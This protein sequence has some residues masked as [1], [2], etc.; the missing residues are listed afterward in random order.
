MRLGRVRG[1]LVEVNLAMAVIKLGLMV[2]AM[3][4]SATPLPFE[5]VMQGWPLTAWWLLVTLVYMAAADFFKMAR[6]FVFLEYL[7]APASV[8]A[9]LRAEATAGPTMHAR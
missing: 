1:K 2:L 8:V 7:R 5:T 9:A 4:F 3:V 6:F